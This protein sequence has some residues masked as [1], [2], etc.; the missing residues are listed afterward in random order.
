M[1]DWFADSGAT[2][3]MTD[4]LSTLVNFSSVESETWTV[5]G[6][7]N[8]QLTVQGRGDV[9]VLSIVNGKT[10]VGVF[11]GVLY[12]PGLGTNLFSIGSA[13]EAG[14][15]VYFIDEKVSFTR[16]GV[17]EMEGQ[18]AGSTLYHLNV[19]AKQH[20]SHP[21]VGFSVKTTTPLSIWHQRLG[22]LN[23]KTVLKMITLG[24][25]NGLDQVNDDSSPNTPCQGCILGI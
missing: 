15:E 3:H 20:N 21:A 6:I 8:T 10:R 22:H 16:Q 14:A 17:V 4:Q 2:Q 23:C 18:R 13:T 9:E 25:V 5:A 1:T 11:K 7:G 19:V 12:V 24:L